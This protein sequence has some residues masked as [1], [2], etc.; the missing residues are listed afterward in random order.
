MLMQRYR[1]PYLQ[2]CSCIERC[3]LIQIQNDLFKIRWT[4]IDKS[5]KSNFHWQQNTENDHVIESTA[6]LHRPWYVKTGIGFL[7]FNHSTKNKHSTNNNQRQIAYFAGNGNSHWS[8]SGKPKIAKPMGANAENANV[9][10]CPAIVNFRKYWAN[11]AF[12][13]S[14]ASNVPQDSL[15]S[16]QP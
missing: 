1:F 15:D 14:A 12:F 3:F 2:P 9:P 16:S 10:I 7:V 4:S 11:N 5:T 6:K 13:C 8:G